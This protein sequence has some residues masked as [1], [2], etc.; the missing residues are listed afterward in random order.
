M[1]SVSVVKSPAG[2]VMVL[3]A[4]ALGRCR[5]SEVD[6]S[7]QSAV[8]GVTVVQTRHKGRGER[9]EESLRTE[10]ILHK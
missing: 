7:A 2:C 10:I 1:L 6:E 9:Y 3:L 4:V 8:S 5:Q